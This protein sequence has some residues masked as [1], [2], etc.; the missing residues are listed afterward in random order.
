MI[1]KFAAIGVM[2]LT[3]STCSSPSQAAE[4]KP[5]IT[6]EKPQEIISKSKTGFQQKLLEIYRTQQL[7]QAIH[8]LRKYVNKTWYVFSGETPNGWDCSGLTRWVYKQ[9]G[10]GLAHSANIQKHSGKKYDIP[11][12]GDIVAFGWKGWAGAVHV[13][14]YVG[15]GMM[16]NAPSPGHLTTLQSVESFAKAG[17]T[18]VTYTR[19]IQT[20]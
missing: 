15:N 3:L 2:A 14:I 5:I 4:S 12:I 9:V 16:I 19:I 18:N 6:Y 7:N 10:I 1:K 20:N 17:Y 13:G 11:K 8:Q